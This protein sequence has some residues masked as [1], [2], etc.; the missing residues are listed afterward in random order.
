MFAIQKNSTAKE[1]FNEAIEILFRKEKEE[2]EKKEE[3]KTNDEEAEPESESKSESDNRPNI[4]FSFFYSH[5]NSNEFVEKHLPSDMPSN[6]HILS[7]SSAKIDFERQIEEVTIFLCGFINLISIFST[8]KIV[9]ILRRRKYSEKY[10]RLKS[11]CQ[12]LPSQRI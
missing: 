7:G 10:V 12:D 6:L 8:I 3:E 4:L 11:S 2:E 1:D 5:L 9:F